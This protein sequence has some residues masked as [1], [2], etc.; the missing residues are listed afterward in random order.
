MANTDLPKMKAARQV[1]EGLSEFFESKGPIDYGCDGMLRNWAHHG[2]HSIPVSRRNTFSLT[3]GRD[4]VPVE[5]VPLGLSYR[6][7]SHLEVG[8]L[9]LTTPQYLYSEHGDVIFHHRATENTEKNKI[10]NPL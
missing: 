5:V 2:L 1:I 3:P 4:P 7:T 10:T 9:S 6:L 8:I